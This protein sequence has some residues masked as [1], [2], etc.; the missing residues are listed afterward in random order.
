V[1]KY[2]RTESAD[3]KPDGIGD[4]FDKLYDALWGM[5]DNKRGHGRRR[6]HSHPLGN[7]PN[8]HSVWY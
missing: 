7:L 4:A 1:L 6:L 8:L 5:G 2:I 3:Y